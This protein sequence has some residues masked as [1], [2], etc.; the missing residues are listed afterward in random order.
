MGIG[1]VGEDR[2]CTLARSS[3]DLNTTNCRS[4]FHLPGAR[5]KEPRC[6]CSP[7]EA[8]VY[9]LDSVALRRLQ[10]ALSSFRM[11]PLSDNLAISIPWLE[12][13]TLLLALQDVDRIDRVI[14]IDINEGQ[15][16]GGRP[17]ESD[18]S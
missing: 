2:S 4:A 9:T 5:Q 6:V 17:E 1:I 10:A 15:S 11:W 7:A 18:A 8:T 14:S 13:F 3:K 12:D 16:I